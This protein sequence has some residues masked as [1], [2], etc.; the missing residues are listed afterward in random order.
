MA[1]KTVK[2]VKMRT[3][4][5]MEA[6]GRVWTCAKTRGRLTVADSRWK[7][8]KTRSIA[9]KMSEKVKSAATGPQ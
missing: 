3:E 2:M 8:V 1:E 5:V 6:L 4:T 9:L 7:R